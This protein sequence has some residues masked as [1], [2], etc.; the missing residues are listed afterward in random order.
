MAT[1]LDRF[2]VEELVSWRFRND[3]DEDDPVDDYSK[4]HTINLAEGE[5]ANQAEVPFRK[6][7]TIAGGA[8]QIIDL[9]GALAGSFGTTVV[10]TKLKFCRV[11]NA[12]TTAAIVRLESDGTSGH[13]GMF[14]AEGDGV[15]IPPGG[16]FSWG[17]P[18]AAGA[19]ITA[20]T[21]DLLN[22][23][24]E[25]GALEAIVFVELAFTV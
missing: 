6:Q 5:G 7:Y 2:R 18:T 17:G 10:G 9:S 11:I 1:V 4:P 16:K 24:N 23:V 3:L 20:A 19:A 13:I 8:T 12:S 22:I 25:D 21:G 14:K 15:Q